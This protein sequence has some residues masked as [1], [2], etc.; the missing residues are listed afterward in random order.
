LRAR[1]N[2]DLQDEANINGLVDFFIGQTTALALLER[3]GS[4][5]ENLQA[6]MKLALSA[7]S[8]EKRE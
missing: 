5:F 4:M 8:L 3:A 6:V 1:K 7:L 2:N